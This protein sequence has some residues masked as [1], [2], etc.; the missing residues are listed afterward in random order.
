MIAIVI[1]SI[2]RYRFFSRLILSLNGKYSILVI[3]TEPYAYLASKSLSRHSKLIVNCFY[4]SMH[5]LV[6]NNITKNIIDSDV[7]KSIEVLNNDISL[8]VA[9]R[10]YERALSFFIKE[11]I[12]YDVKKCIMWNG[13]QL[14]CRAATRACKQLNIDTVYIEIANL[15]RKL[16]VD[17]QGV[18]ALSSIATDISIIDNLTDVNEEK[19]KLWLACYEEYKNKPLPQSKTKLKNKFK[20]SINYFLKLVTPSLLRRKLSKIKLK[21][22]ANLKN[23]KLA[24][25]EV[26]DN[27]DY[28][29]LPLQVS[30]DTQIKLHSKYDNAAAI[31][32][33]LDVSKKTNL[34][35]I[36]KIHPAEYSK[37]EIN[38]ILALQDKHGFYI[39]N[40]NTTHLIKNA[41]KIITINSTVGLEGLLYKKNVE[42][43]G[44][45]FYKNFDQVRLMKYIHQYLVDGV[46]YFSDDPIEFDV[47]ERIINA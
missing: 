28:I 8:S 4:G 22:G 2:E 32:Y 47:S 41:S 33:A 1:D 38:K 11:F 44:N 7:M 19:H 35:L 31:Q 5:I 10:D 46:D 20:S 40:A 39:S 24:G 12:R 6:A 45:C 37:N 16:F 26:V 13:Q 21:N 27:L 17:S 34:D 14:L 42:A 23:I 9:K 25:Y 15:P 43:I 18:N 3:T 36:V 30:G 29:F